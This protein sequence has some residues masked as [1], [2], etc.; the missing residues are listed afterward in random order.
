[1][2]TIESIHLTP[3][4]GGTP[5]PVESARA[6]PGCGFDGDRYAEP[7]PQGGW[8]FSTITLIEAEEVEA[9]GLGPGE[10]RRNVTVRGIALNPL[11]GRQFRVG[12]L[13]C[14]GVELCQPCAYLERT[15]ER[16]GLAKQMINRAGIRAKVL[17]GGEIRVGDVVGS[18]ESGGG[19][20]Q[21]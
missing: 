14:E 8:D 15:T 1:M 17:T 21:A 13:L 5:A 18:S 20:G 6:R 7:D 3:D 19:S 4:S 9:A 16:P 11:V 2:G 10:S 12:E